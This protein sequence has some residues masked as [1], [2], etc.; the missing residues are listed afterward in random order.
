[1]DHA[2]L[3]IEMEY[4]DPAPSLKRHRKKTNADKAGAEVGA[5]ASR[6]RISQL[7]RRTRLS[8][9]SDSESMFSDQ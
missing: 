4:E 3:S 1:M 8:D 9:D 5:K 2:G 6:L 7:G